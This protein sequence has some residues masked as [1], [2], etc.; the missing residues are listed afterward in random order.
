[1]IFSTLGLLDHPLLGQARGVVGGGGGGG[2][3]HGGR[4]AAAGGVGRGGVAEDGAH[5]ADHLVCG[6]VHVGIV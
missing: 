5:G 1:M 4:A 3:G 2:G 6:K